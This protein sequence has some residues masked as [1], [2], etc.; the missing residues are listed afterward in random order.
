[1]NPSKII[2][3]IPADGWCGV[4][5]LT[6][7]PWYF[8]SALACW[9]LVEESHGDRCIVGMDAVDMV[10]SAEETDNFYCYVF[11]SEITDDTMAGWIKI[12]QDRALNGQVR[13]PSELE[14]CDTEGCPCLGRGSMKHWL[15]KPISDVFYNELPW[16]D[17]TGRTTEGGLSPAKIV[18]TD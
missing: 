1:M 9:A 11:H 18:I 7:P 14:M 4:Y 16:N 12:A 10:I 8:A 6:E 17:R 5:L 13:K 3:M 15:M 2:S